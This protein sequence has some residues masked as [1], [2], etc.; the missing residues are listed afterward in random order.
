[1]SGL[2]R[3]PYYILGISQHV[4]DAVVR[5]TYKKLSLKHHPDKAKPEDVVAATEHMKQINDAYHKLKPE[6]RKTTDKKIRQAAAAATPAQKETAQETPEWAKP[7]SW[8]AAS[9]QYWR[10]DPDR[11][12]REQEQQARDQKRW[13]E[14]TK[15]HANHEK[16]K[17][18]DAESDTEYHFQRAQKEKQA[19]EQQE[20]QERI[21]RRWEER[22][23]ERWEERQQANEQNK[24][25]DPH[26]GENH[27]RNAQE[28]AR[29][30]AG[31]NPQW[32][33]EQERVAAECCGFEE[34]YIAIRNS[35]KQREAE[36][37]T[38]LPLTRLCIFGP[39]PLA[40]YTARSVFDD[41]DDLQQEHPLRIR[42]IERVRQVSQHIS[43]IHS[44]ALLGVATDTLVDSLITLMGELE[45]ELTKLH[46]T[47]DALRTEDRLIREYHQGCQG[48]CEYSRYEVENVALTKEM[49][50]EITRRLAVSEPPIKAP[51]W[52][53]VDISMLW[54][55]RFK[56]AKNH[57]GC[58]WAGFS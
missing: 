13:D 16:Q 55:S 17:N 47:V 11:A 27:W 10:D 34:R 4:S 44:R 33:Q 1:M 22:Q 15:K 42:W 45:R 6:N 46:T 29:I 35:L 8:Q 49:H 21:R 56:R 14:Y 36:Y 53:L 43:S 38:L 28:N 37:R 5:F 40:R 19:K 9:E 3:N 7:K 39:D 52:F 2:S 20:Q 30:L 12:R 31:E 24:E 41:Q 23:R 25:N 50:A 58:I 48:T 51:E 26:E 32:N 18:E 57:K 54:Y